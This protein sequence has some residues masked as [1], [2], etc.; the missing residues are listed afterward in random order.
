MTGMFLYLSMI[1]ICTNSNL[2][3]FQLQVHNRPCK[4]PALTRAV[5]RSTIGSNLSPQ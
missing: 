3:S 1:L 5:P 2:T 4:L